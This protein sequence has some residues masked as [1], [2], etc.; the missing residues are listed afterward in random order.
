MAKAAEDKKA[1][2]IEILDIR[3]ISALADYFVIL[4]CE[5]GPQLKAVV[6]GIEELLSK[7]GIKTPMAEGKRESNWLILDLGKVVVHIM[8][9]EERNFYN[10]E[11][12][13][14][15]KAVIYHL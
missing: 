14:G 5:S 12:L 11:G 3:R 6:S 1:G 8:G 10:L 7:K 15:K 2:Q 4:S 9:E 13:W